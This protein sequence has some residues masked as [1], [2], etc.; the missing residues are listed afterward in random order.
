MLQGCLPVGLIVHVA[1]VCSL[2]PVCFDEGETRS[3]FSH[4]PVY[5]DMTSTT[6]WFNKSITSLTSKCRPGSWLS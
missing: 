2:T 4:A 6:Q 1:P 5:D 3:D